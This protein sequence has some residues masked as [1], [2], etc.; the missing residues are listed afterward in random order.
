MKCLQDMYWNKHGVFPGEIG[1][2]I[3]RRCQYKYGDKCV[4][5]DITWDDRI[6]FAIK[7]WWKKRKQ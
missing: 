1:C 7:R 4:C 3:A 2:A 5:E 6:W